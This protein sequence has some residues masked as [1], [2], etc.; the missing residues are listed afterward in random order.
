[1]TSPGR[2]Q[3]LLLELASDGV[4]MT[5]TK[6]HSTQFFIVRA[7]AVCETFKNQA[8]N[9]QA[10]MVVPGPTAPKKYVVFW[11]LILEE[12]FGKCGPHGAP[13]APCPVCL[14][15]ASRGRGLGHCRGR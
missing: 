7:S 2:A 8:R 9:A 6:P 4:E 15:C 13:A 14:A 1:M 3:P 10:V 11:R 12:L 5:K